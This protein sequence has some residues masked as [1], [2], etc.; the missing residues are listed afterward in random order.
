M[1]SYFSPIP[2]RNDWPASRNGLIAWSFDSLV[3]GSQSALTSGRIYFCGVDIQQPAT[4]TNV[5]CSIQATGSGLTSGQNFMGLMN[6]S[7]TLLSKTADQTTNFGSV[8]GTHSAALAAPQAVTPGLYWVLILSVGTPP[9]L[10]RS[11]NSNIN[12][13]ITSVAQFRFALSSAG[14]KTD[15]PDTIDPA[16]YFSSS[17]SGGTPYIVAV[18]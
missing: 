3:L 9:S 10:H 7:G 2:Q 13:G 14:S 16:T 6:S 8:T 17:V 18:S 12:F 1:A 4:I 11:L 5:V 15:L